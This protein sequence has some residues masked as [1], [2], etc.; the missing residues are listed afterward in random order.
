MSSEQ[1]LAESATQQA[2]AAKTR[3]RKMHQDCSPV[4]QI[5]DTDKEPPCTQKRRMGHQEVPEEDEGIFALLEQ[6]EAEMDPEAAAEE[7]EL[8]TMD[9]VATTN[10]VFSFAPVPASRTR[11]RPATTQTRKLQPIVNLNTQT[12]HREAHHRNPTSHKAHSSWILFSLPTFELS[13]QN[14]STIKSRAASFSGPHTPHFLSS[15]AGSSCALFTKHL[16]TTRPLIALI[17]AHTDLVPIVADNTTRQQNTKVKATDYE[18]EFQSTILLACKYYRVILCTK[19]AFPV[20]IDADRFAW[21][22]WQL[23]CCEHE[24][25]YTADHGIYKV[26]HDSSTGLF[27]T[28]LLPHLIRDQWF[29]K[30]HA[31]GLSFHAYFNPIPLPL[32][33]LT[34]VAI[35]NCVDEWQTGHFS[36]LSFSEKIYKNAYQ[37]H[38]DAL[39]KWQAHPKGGPILARLQQ[40]LHDQARVH[41]GAT[42]LQT[43]RLS[44]IT[45]DDFEAAAMEADE[46]PDEYQNGFEQ[47]DK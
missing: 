44:R 29:H 20:E 15:P 25:Q 46:E 11:V 8:D 3:Q 12:A 27:Q 19:D 18:E 47:N 10:N 34:F 13:D 22:A 14:P 21:Q 45:A 9:A 30:P 33:A 35:E 17:N 38:L 28:P 26:D 5:S 6:H 36:A 41:S 24:V 16:K 7:G 31:E 32:I 39:E 43:S 37:E 1:E 2:K 42:V 23:A 40:H 4:P